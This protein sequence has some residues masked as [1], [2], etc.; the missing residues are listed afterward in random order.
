MVEP[1]PSA[2]TD[3]AGVIARPPL[4]FG[5]TLLAGLIADWL[6]DGPGIGPDYAVLVVPGFILVL[7]G[8]ALVFTAAVQFRRAGTNVETWKPSTNLVTTG[9][10]R[11]SRNPIYVG[12]TLIYLGVTLLTDSLVALVLLPLV[13]IFIRFGVIER[14]ER[15][16][17]IKFGEAYRE[18]KGRV[19][20]WI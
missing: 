9:V 14:E 10:Y 15:Y 5:G 6:I 2:E 8:L 7:A 19:R 12:L 11:F 17:E 3:N 20:R 16:L 18:Y 1:G 13:L 4:I